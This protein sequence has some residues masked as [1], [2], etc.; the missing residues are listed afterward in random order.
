M[1]NEDVIFEQL[2]T[3]G[4]WRNNNLKPGLD[5]QRDFWRLAIQKPRTSIII[6]TSSKEV[7][8]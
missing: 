3:A 1:L 2:V 8:K 4:L 7:L 6:Q 5:L